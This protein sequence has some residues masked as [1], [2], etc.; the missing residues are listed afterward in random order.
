M[1]ARFPG[2]TTLPRLLGLFKELTQQRQGFCSGPLT[3]EGYG[4]LPPSTIE[5]VEFKP[6][7]GET[8]EMGPSVRE[9][10]LNVRR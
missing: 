7:K 6:N 9:K 3:D 4:A 2:A 8:K 1:R 5:F 10:R